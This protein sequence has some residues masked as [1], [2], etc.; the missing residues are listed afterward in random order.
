MGP[1]VSATWDEDVRA[2]I[3]TV[4]GRRDAEANALLMR[5]RGFCRGVVLS[6]HAEGRT[7]PESYADALTAARGAAWA[8]QLEDDAILAP[9]FD[10]RALELIDVASRL[11][12][13]GLV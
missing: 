1:T 11:P 2:S 7:V 9:D 8:M 13:V 5:V 12:R 10:E 3:R 4:P 6:P